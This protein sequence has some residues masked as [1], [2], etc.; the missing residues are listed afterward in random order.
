MLT[1]YISVSVIILLVSCFC[2]GYIKNKDYMR[3]N[4]MGYG[5]LLALVWPFCIVAACVLAPFCLSYYL[6]KY[7]QKNKK[8][9]KYEV[10]Q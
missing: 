6:G 8:L 10:E 4:F 5:A 7:V 9:R 1:I 2:S 3:I